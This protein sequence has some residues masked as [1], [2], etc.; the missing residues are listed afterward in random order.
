MSPD[1]TR[2][3]MSRLVDARGAVN[4]AE[5][6]LVDAKDAMTE[7]LDEL[8]A[9]TDALVSA[10]AQEA[11]AAQVGRSGEA[12]ETPLG[13]SMRSTTSAVPNEDSAIARKEQ[14]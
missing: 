9:A 14:P 2:G 6:R 10:L 11:D 3:L 12:I 7:A 5:S 13:G 8:F 1:E 4:R